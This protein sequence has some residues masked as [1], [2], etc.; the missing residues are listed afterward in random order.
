[1]ASN[2]DYLSIETPENI[3]FGYDVA[4]IGSRFLAAIVDTIVI[5]ILQIIVNLAILFLT[6]NLFAGFSESETLIWLGAIFSLISF[7]LLWGYYIIF[8]MIWNGQSP[9]KRWVGLRVIR[10]DGS[11]ITLIESIIRNLVRL[12]DFLPLYYGVGVVTMFVNEQSRRLGDL[13]AGTLVVRDRSPISLESL[14]QSAI[15]RADQA[16]PASVANLPLERLTDRTIQMVE[17]Y[18]HR[19]KELANNTIVCRQILQAVYDQMRLPPPE[20]NWWASERLLQDIVQGYK[21][22][23]SD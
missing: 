4:G 11:P 2:D 23:R 6:N 8:E 10:I 14:E 9:G 16:I 21:S 7:L 18:L 19:R 13:A 1:M 15:R 3:A 12:V 17:D 20:L 5:V 22:R